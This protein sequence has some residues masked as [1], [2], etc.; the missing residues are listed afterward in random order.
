MDWWVS[1]NI[2]YNTALLLLINLNNYFYVSM[3]FIPLF[4]ACIMHNFLMKCILMYNKYLCNQKKFPKLYCYYHQDQKFPFQTW[5]KDFKFEVSLNHCVEA[6]CLDWMR[7][8]PRTVSAGAVEVCYYM[9]VS[10]TQV[11]ILPVGSHV[12]SE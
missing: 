12:V 4:V 5:T 2:H 1:T 3:G 6:Y 8:R 10:Q 9:Q 7:L 11:N